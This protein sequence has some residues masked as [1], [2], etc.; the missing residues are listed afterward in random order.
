MLNIRLICVGKLKERFY[1]DAANEYIKRLSSYCKLEVIEIS[2]CRLS[3]GGVCI[4]PEVENLKSGLKSDMAVRY[5][6]VNEELQAPR[7]LDSQVIFALNKERAAIEAKMPNGAVNIAM[8]IEGRELDSYGL[9]DLLTDCAIQGESRLCFIIG[10]SFGLHDNIKKIADIRLSMS[11][12]TFPHTLARIML[13]EQLYRAFKIA[14][15]GKYH[16]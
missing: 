14:E 4:K 5:R 8:C 11:K 12:M 7:C 16:K 15:G 1:T 3:T 10:G 9:S 6:Q 13:L 2:E